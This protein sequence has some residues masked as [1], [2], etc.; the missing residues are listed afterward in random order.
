METDVNDA[1]RNRCKSPR[2]ATASVGWE[3]SNDRHTIPNK[4]RPMFWN[5]GAIGDT[6][7]THCSIR[8]PRCNN[9]ESSLPS[10]YVFAWEQHVDAR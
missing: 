5:G 9:F 8:I 1:K 4:T 6:I 10:F 2:T 7:F 3:L